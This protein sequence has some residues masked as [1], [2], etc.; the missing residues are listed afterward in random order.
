[1]TPSGHGHEQGDHRAGQRQGAADAQLLE[2]QRADVGVGQDR[3]AEVAVQQAAD[4]FEVAHPAGLVEAKLV[5]QGLERLRR[6]A[7]AEDDGGDVAGQDVDDDEDEDR[8]HQQAHDE[9][10]EADDYEDSHTTESI[11]RGD[12]PSGET[13]LFCP[14]G[15]P[16]EAVLGAAG[17]PP[18]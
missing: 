6:G 14:W 17:T 4:P 5:A 13:R 1:M 7:G 12:P 2:D 11:P 16:L 18:L 10:E 8:G 3:G 15:T 9:P